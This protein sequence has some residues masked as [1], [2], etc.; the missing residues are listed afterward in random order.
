MSRHL[1]SGLDRSACLG[2]LGTRSWGRLVY[3]R[4]AL[5]EVLPVPYHLEGERVL[6]RLASDSAA[7]DASRDAVVAFE[8][9]DFDAEF[10]SGWTVTIVGLAQEIAPSYE[11]ERL[12]GHVLAVTVDRMS[13]HRLTSDGTPSTASWAALT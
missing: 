11:P 4:R 2:L 7:A 12:V 9:D 6:I 8:V 13:G 1:T 10:R 3:T 5:P